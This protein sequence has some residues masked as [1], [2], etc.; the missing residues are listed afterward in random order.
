MI[1]KMRHFML[2]DAKYTILLQKIYL[3]NIIMKA[4][5]K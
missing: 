5:Q 4:L 3:Y 1:F 2:I